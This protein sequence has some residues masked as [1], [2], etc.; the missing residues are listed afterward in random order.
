M[1][2]VVIRK[3]EITKKTSTPTKPPAKMSN[4][5]WKKIT[6][7]TATARSPSISRRYFIFWSLQKGTHR[8]HARGNMRLYR[9][10]H[11]MVQAVHRRSGPCRRICATGC[12]T[13]RLALK[14]PG[15]N[16]PRW[17]KGKDN[18]PV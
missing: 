8:D 16:Q 11:A 15:C 9:A 3:P 1:M 12:Q 13:D 6:G 17:L 18:S 7:S 5:A 14:Y 10:R 4:P 2:I